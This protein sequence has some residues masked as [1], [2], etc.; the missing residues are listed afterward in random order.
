MA[1][2]EMHR[3]PLWGIAATIVGRG[4]DARL[5]WE[6][7][8]RVDESR[9]LPCIQVMDL[10]LRR[11][12]PDTEIIII[13]LLGLA[14]AGYLAASDNGAKRRLRGSASQDHP[15]TDNLDK[16]FDRFVRHF[17]IS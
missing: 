16:G 17:T 14:P 1:I 3:G 12:A 4:E 5:P 15:D 11:A 7:R 13:H 9:T 10:E 6:Y 2:G 8:P